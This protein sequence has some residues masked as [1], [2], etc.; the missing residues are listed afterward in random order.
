MT[1]MVIYTGRAVPV[2]GF[3]TFIYDVL[4]KEKLVESWDEYLEHIGSGCWFTKMDDV[5][6]EPLEE[7]KEEKPRKKGSK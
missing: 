1:E 7:E 4:G 2:Q 5:P 3:R 6:F